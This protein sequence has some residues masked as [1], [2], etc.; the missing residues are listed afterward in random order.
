MNHFFL[1]FLKLIGIIKDQNNLFL[2]FV[3]ILDEE[4]SAI[5]Q[6]SMRLIEKSLVTKD[7]YVKICES[8]EEKRNITI[9]KLFHMMA[10]DTRGLKLSVT[11]FETVLNSYIQNV[12]NLLSLEDR[13]Q[14]ENLEI[15]FQNVIK[16][17]KKTFKIFSE[18]S[19]RNKL[20]L[21]KLSQHVRLSLQLFETETSK[22]NN[23]NSK[24]K[25]SSSLSHMKPS[26]ILNVK[27]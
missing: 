24:G 3:N 13:N 25:V 9:K 6:Y 7:Q 4:E 12:K 2:Q 15:T 10:F 17:F 11:L 27:V 21:S 14:L 22:D 26:S 23:Y 1:E 20:I 5:A 8:M 19:Y 18:R 16:D